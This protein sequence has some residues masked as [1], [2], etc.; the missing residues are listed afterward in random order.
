M[1]ECVTEE[2]VKVEVGRKVCADTDRLSWAQDTTS[3]QN[4][5]LFHAF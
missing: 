5:W 1:Y 4:D 3:I 2:M